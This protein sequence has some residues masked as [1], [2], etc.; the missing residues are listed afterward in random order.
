MFLPHRR[1]DKNWGCPYSIQKATHSQQGC[2]T[3]S[4]K[5][6]AQ[7]EGKIMLPIKP[8]LLKTRRKWATL[9]DHIFTGTVAPSPAPEGAFNRLLRTGVQPAAVA[10]CTR[11]QS[12]ALGAAALAGWMRPALTSPF[13]PGDK[14]NP[15]WQQAFAPLH[16]PS[17]ATLQH[18]CST[19]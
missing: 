3:C 9:P 10:S 5:P 1:M 16:P 17:A 11:E 15:C 2:P 8:F 4:R 14:W 18:S 12:Q 7:S 19:V 13:L 6:C